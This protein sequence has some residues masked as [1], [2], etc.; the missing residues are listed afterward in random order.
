[1]DTKIETEQARSLIVDATGLVGGYILDRLVRAGERPLALSRS[2]QSRPDVDW[3]CGDL[4]KQ[5]TLRFPPFSTLYCT[6]DAT[7]L[8]AALPRFF[9]P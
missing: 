3:F 1:V 7:L 5:D 4:A 6:A 2:P 9:N 8:P